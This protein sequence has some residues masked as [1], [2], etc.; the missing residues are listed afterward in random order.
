MDLP[1]ANLVA[2]AQGLLPQDHPAHRPANPQ[3][4]DEGVSDE[5]GH[6]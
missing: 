4:C 6:P 3:R 2:A 1:G 5:M